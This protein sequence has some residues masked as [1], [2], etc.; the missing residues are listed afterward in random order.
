MS[1]T[2]KPF[3][4]TPAG[5]AV[6]EYTLTNA[7]GASISVCDFGGILTKIFM[8]DRNGKLDDF[9]LGFVNVDVYAGGKSG[10]M[11]MLIGRVANR[12]KGATFDLEGKTYNLPKNNLGNCLHGGTPGFGMRMWQAKPEEAS[13]ALVLTLV[14]EDGDQGFPGRVDVTVTYS[15][16]ENNELGIH[17]QA[18]TDKTTIV[19]MTNHAYFHLDGH[20][21]GTV[22]E[23]ELQIN[24]GLVTEVGEGLIPTGRLLPV[25]QV[26]YNFSSMTRMRACAWKPSTIRIPSISRTSPA[27]SLGPRMRTIP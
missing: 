2:Q 4:T 23:Q 24:A 16:S 3:G 20:A 27:S 17:Y 1:I 19:S 18:R 13:N 10:S 12:I 7:S 15:L 26:P 5:E 14:S 25:E 8:P 6:T 11:G 21:F 22:A 9:N